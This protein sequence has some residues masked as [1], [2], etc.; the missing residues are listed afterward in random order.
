MHAFHLVGLTC[1]RT[2]G[3]DLYYLIMNNEVWQ[4]NHHH[5]CYMY[6][7]GKGGQGRKGSSDCE[8][9]TERALWSYKDSLCQSIQIKAIGQQ[10]LFFGPNCKSFSTF[11]GKE[12][13]KAIP[14][15]YSHEEVD[16][17][18]CIPVSMSHDPL[19]QNSWS[20]WLFSCLCPV[21]DSHWLT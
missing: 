15:L 20:Q 7:R 10:I 4:R 17:L 9:W 18:S 3:K 13:K 8:S 1:M 2:G 11:P 16:R 6:K 5:H 12:K 21:V 14:L 19:N